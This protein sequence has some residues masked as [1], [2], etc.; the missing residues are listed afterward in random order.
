VCYVNSGSCQ[1]QCNYGSAYSG[2][3]I[4][5]LVS[6]LLLEICRQQDARHTPSL[7]ANT[8]D[9]SWILLCQLWSGSNPLLLQ[10]CIFTRTNL[11]CYYLLCIEFDASHTPHW[12]AI[13]AHVSR[14]VVCQLWSL[15]NPIFLFLREEILMDARPPSGRRW[16]V[17]DSNPQKPHVGRHDA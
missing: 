15:S 1:I 11:H 12:L 3:Y 13:T 5:L 10:F 6:P 17:S 7:L 2:L 4:Q 16:V 14:F 9:V 8:A